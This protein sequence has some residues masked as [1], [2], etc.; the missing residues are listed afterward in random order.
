M[1]MSV[2]NG[3]LCMSGCDAAKAR[4]GENPREADPMKADKA[5]P[6]PG[7]PDPAV[8]FGGAL[9]ALDRAAAQA[10]ETADGAARRS[11][12]RGVDILV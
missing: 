12:A 6:V 11:L 5:T 8:R 1:S 9:A 4:Q 2:V 3:Y 10:A 7:A